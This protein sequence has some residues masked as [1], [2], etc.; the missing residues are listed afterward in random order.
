M[1]TERSRRAKRFKAKSGI[2]N[3]LC[4]APYGYNYIRKTELTTV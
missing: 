3:A 1:I 2:E 4:G